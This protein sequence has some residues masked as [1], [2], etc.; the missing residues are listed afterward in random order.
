VLREFAP[1]LRDGGRLLVVASR[2]GRLRALAPVRHDRFERPQ[3][4]DEVDEA[5]R[6]W[7]DAV[8]S[9]RAPGRAWP[10]WID[11]P[12]KIGQVAAVRV[13]ARERRAE[14]QRRGILI[15]AG[16]PASSTPGRR[17]PG[18]R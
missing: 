1:R 4:L 17:A 14:D 12:S 13:L 15:A 8:R 11:I 5:V 9:G 16:C 7:R 6:S 2:A 3:S 10:A 18:W